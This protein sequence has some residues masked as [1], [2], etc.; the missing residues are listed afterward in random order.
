M[1]LVS[2][3]RVRATDLE[4]QTK[5]YKINQIHVAL[6]EPTSVLSVLYLRR[7]KEHH[8]PYGELVCLLC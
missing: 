8:S 6:K 4:R 7:T 5:K 3:L 2:N 1:L